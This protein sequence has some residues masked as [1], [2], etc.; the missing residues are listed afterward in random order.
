MYQSNIAILFQWKL[1]LNHWLFSW[2]ELYFS[3]MYKW[4]TLF[5]GQLGTFSENVKLSMSG[6]KISDIWYNISQMHR[7]ASTGICWPTTEKCH[8]FFQWSFIKEE[9]DSCGTVP[10]WGAQKSDSSWNAGKES[11]QASQLRATH[12]QKKHRIPTITCI[13]W[14]LTCE[15]S[16]ARCAA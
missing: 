3:R 14:T 11:Q 6:Y 8:K 12:S 10:M 15:S 7:N 2:K 9:Q 16:Q 1:S 4:Q 5:E 13:F